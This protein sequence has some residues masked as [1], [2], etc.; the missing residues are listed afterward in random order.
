MNK[1]AHAI[2]DAP[3]PFITTF[4]SLIFFFEISKALIKAAV[5]IIAVPCWS[6]WKTGI[7]RI[8][9]NF[10][11][12][13]KQSGAAISSRLIPPNVPAIFFIVLI[14]SFASL[15]ST[16]ISIESI[17]ANLL[18]KTAFP[19]IT[20]FEARAPKLPSPRIADPLLITATKFPFEV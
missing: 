4:T 12:I 5:V 11:S 6:S 13:I 19:S 8:S 20:G 17:S 9:F 14:I 3:A 7:S 10:C 1:L 18:N 16:S 15:L 2:A